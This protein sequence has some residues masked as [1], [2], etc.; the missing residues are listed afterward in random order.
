AVMA[1][2]NNNSPERKVTWDDFHSMT[3]SK[4]VG[5]VLVLTVE[6][7]CAGSG[8]SDSGNHGS[9]NALV[10]HHYHASNWPSRH[11]RYSHP[12]FGQ[13]E[14]CN[15]NADCVRQWDKDV[16]DFEKLSEQGKKDKIRERLLLLQPPPPPPAP[17]QQQPLEQPLKL[18]ESLPQLPKQPE[19]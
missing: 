13:V 17:A 5:R 18:P 16:A 19:Q 12:A 11:R 8:H 7:F 4:V 6:A 9:R 1:E 2:M 3:E 15:W 14:E 10:E